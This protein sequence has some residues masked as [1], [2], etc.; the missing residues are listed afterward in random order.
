[1]YLTAGGVVQG[2][3]REAGQITQVLEEVQT[4]HADGLWLQLRHLE[5]HG[6]VNSHTNTHNETNVNTQSAA[7]VEL[8]TSS[9]G[10]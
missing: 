8:K 2:A 7:S 9:G 5:T 3:G 1:M 10:N 6:D 4:R